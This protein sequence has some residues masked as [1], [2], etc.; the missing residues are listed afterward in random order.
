MVVV[1]ADLQIAVSTA[2]DGNKRHNEDKHT[3]TH[4]YV[5]VSA[6]S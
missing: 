1:E 5:N 3:T 6:V 2:Q 4:I